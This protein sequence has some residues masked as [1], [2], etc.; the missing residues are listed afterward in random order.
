MTEPAPR[1]DSLIYGEVPAERRRRA[2]PWLSPVTRAWSSAGGR[3]RDSAETEAIVKSLPLDP[4]ITTE[5]MPHPSDPATTSTL[6]TE[7]AVT[8]TA[9]K[10]AI[11]T[12]G[13]QG[14][15]AG[16][17]D[18]YRQRGW[19]VVRILSTSSR[20]RTRTSSRSRATSPSRPP[21]TGS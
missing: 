15:G 1:I 13:S 12:G 8:E 3:A 21:P 20:R 10:V 9:Q 4:W 19:A 7:K 2:P 18:G 16:L 6:R 14:I 5:V 17:V 11:V